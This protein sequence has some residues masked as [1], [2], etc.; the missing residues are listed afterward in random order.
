LNKGEKLDCDNYDIWHLKIQYVLNEQEVLETLTHSL[1]ALEQGDIEQHTHDLAAFK[2]W[3]KKDRCARFTMLSSMHNDLIGDFEEYPTAQELWKALKVQYGR[4]SATSLRG[5]TM[6]FDSYKMRSKHTMKQHLRAMSTMICELKTVGNN[7]IDEQQ[8]QAVICSLPSSWE[9]ISQNMTHDENIKSFNDVA[10]HLEIEAEHLE[11]AKPNG[12]IYMAETNSRRA[13]RPKRKSPDYTLGQVQPSGPAPKKAKTTKRTT[14]GKRGGK[15]DK[16]K[17]T[18]YNCGKKG[19]FPRECTES[20]KVTT[21]PISRCVFVTSHV[22][23]A[24]STP[25]WTVDSA[26]TDHVAQDRV[27]FVEFCWIAIGSRN[28][29]VRNEASVEVLGIGTYKLDLRGGR[30]LLLHDVLYAPEI[31]R[32]L[33]S[34]LVL[35]R[36]G[37]RFVF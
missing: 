9:T 32:N 6:K 3:R 33:L 28:I 29:T 5:L 13:S 27:G 14:K 34:L 18:C 25:V 21:N 16:S 35:L 17:L 23:I 22:M 37:F 4:T 24:H 12:S 31:R 15:K 30:T 1:N 10:R 36:L 19:H 11:A 20:K 7:L 26:T 2:S 8:V